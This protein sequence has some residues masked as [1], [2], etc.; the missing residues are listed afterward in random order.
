VERFAYAVHKY[1]AIENQLH[2]CL[3][4]IFDEDSSRVRKDMSPLNLNILRKTALVLCKN[5]DFGR[6]VSIQ[7][8]RFIAAFNPKNYFPSCLLIFK[9][10]CPG[11]GKTTI[12]ICWE[13]GYTKSG[14]FIRAVFRKGENTKNIGEIESHGHIKENTSIKNC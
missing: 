1:W 6:R 10:C 14:R 4:V 9:C 8:K 11:R 13:I 5:A 3:D 2:R 7:K 12:E